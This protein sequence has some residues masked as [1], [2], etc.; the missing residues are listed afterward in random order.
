MIKRI[1]INLQRYVKEKHKYYI[2]ENNQDDFFRLELLNSI[3]INLVIVYLLF[4]VYSI[5]FFVVDILGIFI[6]SFIAGINVFNF[7]ETYKFVKNL[8]FE[9]SEISSKIFFIL[10][11]FLNLSFYILIFCLS[12]YKV[13]G[14]ALKIDYIIC[15]IRYIINFFK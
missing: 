4:Q 15:V 3:F 9:T 12:V 8:V 6:F 11:G 14:I 7:L 10:L 2:K 1:K 5:K 13:E